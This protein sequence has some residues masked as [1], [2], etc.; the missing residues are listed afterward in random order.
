MT[1]ELWFPAVQMKFGLKPDYAEEKYATRL[2]ECYCVISAEIKV[3]V[4]N[5]NAR[6][7]AGINQYTNS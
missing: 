3:T 4:C 1:H 5:E 7:A 6:L 2:T